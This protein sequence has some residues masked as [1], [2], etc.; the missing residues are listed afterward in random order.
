MN[1]ILSIFLF[2]FCGLCC[3]AQSIEVVKMAQ[4][5]RILHAKSDTT[6]VVNFWATWC[7]PCIK[8]FPAFQSFAM[9]HLNEKVKV[10]MVSL[11]F[12]KEYEKTLPPFL[13]KHPIDA[14]VW[15]FDEPDYNAW[16]DK[17]DKDWQGEIPVTLMFNNGRNIRKFYANDFTP[18]SLEKS[19]SNT[20]KQ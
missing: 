10:I 20:I 7:V 13:V 5:E 19:F 15:L 12:K 4:L 14:N 8:E 11:D 3:R 17:V 18:E 2:L 1:R 16:I 9:N 6:Y